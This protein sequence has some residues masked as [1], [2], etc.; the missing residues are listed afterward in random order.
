[1][2]VSKHPNSRP[3]R[4]CIDGTKPALPTGCKPLI[5]SAALLLEFGIVLPRGARGIKQVPDI[6]MNA[7]ADL[8]HAGRWALS[9]QYEHYRYLA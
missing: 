7:G 2:S 8:P 9:A 5:K 6:V 4:H 3:I 1:M